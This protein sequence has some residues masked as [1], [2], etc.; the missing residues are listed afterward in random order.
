MRQLPLAYQHH[1]DDNRPILKRT[2]A[3]AAK[4]RK[5]HAINKAV[6]VKVMVRN[7]ILTELEAEQQYDSMWRRV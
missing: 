4:L 6:Y 1:S 7:N 5:R 2:D 3:E